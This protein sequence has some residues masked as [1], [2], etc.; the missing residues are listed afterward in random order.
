[1]VCH[2]GLELL[3]LDLLM[4]RGQ[5]LRLIVRVRL[6]LWALALPVLLLVQV[7]SVLVGL[8][9]VPVLLAPRQV[10]TRE[11][12]SLLNLSSL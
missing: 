9:R 4:L 12:V 1:M 10:R 3:E 2:L 7:R 11:D 6:V 5:L 8:L